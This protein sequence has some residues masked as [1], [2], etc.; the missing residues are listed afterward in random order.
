MMLLI[1]DVLDKQLIDRNGVNIGKVDSLVIEL[2]PDQPPR[3]A[4]IELGAIALARRLGPRVHR[5]VAVLATR[6][7]GKGRTRARRI[8]WKKVHV[9]GPTIEYEGD[10]QRTV[11]FAWQKWL[12]RRVINR[13]PGGGR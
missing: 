4:F 12:T 2:Q 5:V 11:L 3:V 7:A 1:R 8:A 13:I 10:A 6:I 9:A